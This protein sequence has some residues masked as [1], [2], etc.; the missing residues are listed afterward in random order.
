MTRT[1]LVLHK[2]K[3]AWLTLIRASIVEL[4]KIILVL[5]RYFHEMVGHKKVVLLFI[6]NHEVHNVLLHNCKTFRVE[7][8]V[9]V[10][11]VRVRYRDILHLFDHD[12]TGLI[13]GP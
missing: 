1:Q 6:I 9:L 2:Q 5:E 4:Q 7:K 3:N 13:E 12:H 8:V 11:E 10:H